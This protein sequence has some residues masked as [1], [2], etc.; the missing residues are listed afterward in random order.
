MLNSVIEV[1]RNV[2]KELGVW[3]K[4][5]ELIKPIMQWLTCKG[6]SVWDGFAGS[7]TFGVV[8]KDLELDYEGFEINETTCV[9]ANKRITSKQKQSSL[10]D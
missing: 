1:P 4:P 3:G 5:I 6:E 2:G 7:G 10:F 9:K 8:A